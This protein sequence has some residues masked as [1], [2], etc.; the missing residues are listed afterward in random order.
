M[1]RASYCDTRTRVF[2]VLLGICVVRK[3]SFFHNRVD[4][5][6]VIDTYVMV[7]LV[8]IFSPPSSIGGEF[9]I[10]FLAFLAKISLKQQPHF[11]LCFPF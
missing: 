4:E 8:I 2:L 7:F 5:A 1:S 3:A 11:N 10:F 6:Y 9:I